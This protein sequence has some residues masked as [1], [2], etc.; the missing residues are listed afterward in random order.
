MKHQYN[1]RTNKGDFQDALASI[2]QSLTLSATVPAIP[3]HNSSHICKS[4]RL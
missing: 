4:G 3:N 1:A 2:E